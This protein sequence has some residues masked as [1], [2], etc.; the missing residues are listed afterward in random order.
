MSTKEKCSVI[1]LAGYIINT[2][3]YMALE[4][5]ATQITV[6]CHLLFSELHRDHTL[7]DASNS[8]DAHLNKG[9]GQAACYVAAM[10]N[11]PLNGSSSSLAKC[12]CKGMQCKEG[13]G[14]VKGK[15]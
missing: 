2:E 14:G 6:A 13:G 9:K 8:L 15:E 1:I 5:P 11:K 12:C 4:V 7:Q 10:G 3:N